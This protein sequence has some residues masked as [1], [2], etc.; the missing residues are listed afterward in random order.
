MAQISAF[1]KD[2]LAPP[3]EEIT[4]RTT[5]NIQ[6]SNAEALSRIGAFKNL[7]LT[8][9]VNEALKD[10]SGKMNNVQTIDK[11]I[12]KTN[13]FWF[14]RDEDQVIMLLPIEVAK[15]MLPYQIAYLYCNLKDQ[16]D[17]ERTFSALTL[18]EELKQI[19]AL[20]GVLQKCS[21]FDGEK[22]KGYNIYQ[23]A[24][25]LKAKLTGIQYD[26]LK[27]KLGTASL[28]KLEERR[29]D[30]FPEVDALSQTDGKEA[31]F[32]EENMNPPLDRVLAVTGLNKE[33]WEQLSNAK[34]QEI[35]SI[36]KNNKPD[37]AK[38][39]ISSVIKLAP[40]VALL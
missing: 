7:S 21:E 40:L 23:L 34:K 20:N 29:P 3:I 9:M 10:Y 26:Y 33:E 13:G 28:Q 25:D 5:L 35:H 16:A 22:L 18:N 14:E 11:M 31:T 6:K 30:I 24:I 36:V 4:V 39:L 27:L 37:R 8:A 1:K 2:I 15:K 19:N 17:R 12:S 38:Q 32:S